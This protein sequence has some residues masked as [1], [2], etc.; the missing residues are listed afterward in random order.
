MYTWNLTLHCKS[1]IS[2]VQLLSCVWLFVTPC[3]A[4]RQ[5]SLSIINSW[6]LL[7]LMS[8]ELVM[9]STH[10]ILCGPLLQTSVCLSIRVFSGESVLLIRW[11][12]YWSFSKWSLNIWK[13]SVHVLLKPGLENIEHYFTS[14]WDECNCVVVWAFFGIGNEN[15]PFPVLWPLLSFPNLLA[16]WVP[17]F[18][19]W[20]SS[21]G[22]P[23]PPL[24]VF[25]V[26]L[27]KA[28][29]LHIPGCLAL[30][31]WSHGCGY[32]GHE[33]LFCTVLL[34]IHITFFI[35]WLNVNKAQHYVFRI[36]I[37][38]N[39]PILINH[40][41]G[42]LLLVINCSSRP[43]W[44]PF[45]FTFCFAPFFVSYILISTASPTMFSFG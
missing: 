41:S 30:G 24:A 38:S 23:S 34:C 40:N 16:Y 5:A 31:G 14:M 18:R 19:I 26:M 4:A 44:T 2:S 35:Y 27:S 6:S 3:T 13:F 12:K 37:I 42:P 22:I 36:V 15:W 45:S 20:N 28:H 10:L 1:V 7:R 32:L 11:P 9:P 21:T 25:I 8:L 33:D 39:V 17:S 43:T 29:W